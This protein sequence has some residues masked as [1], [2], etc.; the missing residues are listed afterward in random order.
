MA[1]TPSYE[2]A[3]KRISAFAAAGRKTGQINLND[4]IPTGTAQTA[5]PFQPPV[6]EGGFSL[7]QALI[8]TL[9]AG[10]YAVAGIGQ[11]IGE[12]VT[13][14]N[15]GDMGGALDLFNPLSAL[16]AAGG[17]IQNRRTWSD[18]L[19]DW[20]VA[21]DDSFWPGLALDVALDP[22]WLIP[23]GAI[24]AGVKGTAKGVGLASAATR[25]GISLTR[26]ALEQAGKAGE[27][28]YS[29]TG[30]TLP[31]EQFPQG[32]T[33]I[34]NLLEGVRYGNVDEYGKW[35]TARQARKDA[36]AAA[37][38]APVEPASGTLQLNQSL[39]DDVISGITPS[40]GATAAKTV[41]AVETPEVAPAAEQ[42][43]N[44]LEDVVEKAPAVRAVTDE[45]KD[46]SATVEK[47]EN[48][49]GTR[50]VNQMAREE[51]QPLRDAYNAARGIEDPKFDYRLIEASPLADEI[52][53]AYVKMVDD[54]TNP[55]VIA[56]YR[57]LADEVA[58]QY[59]YMVNDLGIKVE[60]VDFE[61]YLGAGGKVDSK[62]MMQDVA[63]NKHMFIR[64]SDIDAD[65]A[66]GRAHP[67][68]TNEENDM[69]RTVHDFF[70]HAASG[71]GFGKDGEEAAWVAHS[72]MF[73]PEARRAMTTETR[74]QN[75]YYNKFGEF[76]PQKAGLLPE[77]YILLPTEYSALERRVEG[78]NTF[79]GTAANALQELADELIEQLGLI[80]SPLRGVKAYSPEEITQ[81]KTKLDEMFQTE[82]Y[83][84]STQVGQSTLRLLEVLKDLV[85][86]PTA[87]KYASL[88]AGEGS[89]TGL[90]E[91]AQKAFD[92]ASPGKQKANEQA[93]AAF[94]QLVD[95]PIDATDLLESALRAEDRT[96]NNPTPFKPTAWTV[97]GLEYGKPAFSLAKL[98][99]LFPD[100]ELL[101]NQEQLDLAMGNVKVR[102]GTKRA[103]ELAEKQAIIWD[104]FRARNH[105]ILEDVAQVERTDWFANNSIDNSEIFIQQADGSIL[106]QGLLPASIPPGVLTVQNG[107]PTTTLGAVLSNLGRVIN[108]TGPQMGGLPGTELVGGTV[109]R[110]KPRELKSNKKVAKELEAAGEE[111]E[112]F[113]VPLAQP[114]SEIAGKGRLATEIVGGTFVSPARKALRAKLKARGRDIELDTY[115]EALQ[116]WLLTQIDTLTAGVRTKGV[117]D[118]RLMDMATDI[119]AL[120]T[121]LWN[122][123]PAIKS[124]SDARL[125]VTLGPDAVKA[126]SKAPALR[127]F[128]DA[129]VDRLTGRPDTSGIS[130][131]TVMKGSRN[132]QGQILRDP[133]TGVPV[134][135][136]GR[137]V[138]EE[139]GLEGAVLDDNGVVKQGEKYSQYRIKTEDGKPFTGRVKGKYAVQSGTGPQQLAGLQAIRATLGTISEGITKGELA[140]SKE[141]AQLLSN[142]MQ[143]LGIKVAENATPAKIFKQF[144]DEAAVAFEDVIRG[145]E[146]A[147]KSESMV[148]QLKTIFPA[149]IK[150]NISLMKAIER[151]DPADLQLRTVKWTDDAMAMVDDSCS[152]LY[153]PKRAE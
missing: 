148:Y 22:L 52:A 66:T 76:A 100:D 117:V 6:P 144:Q 43:V 4:I 70:G 86:A 50:S 3:Y 58:D 119:E 28:V 114:I 124:R 75:S 2:D 5:Q 104:H 91:L 80:S 55:E 56:A 12:N 141:Q 136:K 81:I 151:I 72:V 45:A 79:I 145:L 10:S 140:S 98:T 54:P 129:P 82:R 135:A 150:E 1:N 92:V 112:A 57:K 42:I 132:E 99:K 139:K 93:L 64:R 15:E 26:P 137:P 87:G 102:P 48:A 152:L 8:D 83:A 33:I 53:D 143:S 41:K 21:E 51:V 30:V 78:S 122:D 11:K 19:Q 128:I 13:A 142:V 95:Q 17:G 67:L 149:A 68:L 73:S 71:R 14:I 46:V 147:A 107:R 138:P 85:A 39:I 37:K 24:V 103:K 111:V 89:I 105:D 18:N 35:A 84:P 47:V 118:R 123:V 108:R 126:L 7:G 29:K 101:R 134:D 109:R 96:I 34:N 115:P 20:G 120:V 77:P 130:R 97:K 90:L 94:R 116:D 146:S 74:G 127:Y 153:I 110:A 59:N 65:P 113:T 133:V 69:F 44:T 16:G 25:G 88:G 32:G 49:T 38:L 9:S 61:P 63:E 27:I 106:G 131:T 31:T 40:A 60:F 23:G 121:R 36:K 125:L 62:L